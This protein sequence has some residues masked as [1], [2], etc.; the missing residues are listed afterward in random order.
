M[1]C[2]LTVE[3][4]FSGL[5]RAPIVYLSTLAFYFAAVRAGRCK[6]MRRDAIW[7]AFLANLRSLVFWLS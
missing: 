7:T 1:L 6:L 3:D 5:S 4:A 2:R